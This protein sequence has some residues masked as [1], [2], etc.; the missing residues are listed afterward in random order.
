MSAVSQSYPNYLGGLNE[1]PDELKKPGQLVEALNVI[2]DPTVGLSRRPGFEHLP[3]SLVLENELDVK[4]DPKGTW[5]EITLTNQV[6]DDYIYFGNVRRDGAIVIFN[7]D[8]V[9]Q[10]VRYTND[11]ISLP[12]HKK[13]LYTDNDRVSVLDENDEEIQSDA[14]RSTSN[15]GYFRHTEDQP[16]KWCVSKNN[17]IFTNPK[18]T[19]TLSKGKKAG[20][21]DETTYY[22][23]ISLKVVDT[24]NYNY[25]FKLFGDDENTQKYRYIT[26]VETT[27]V[28][29]VEADYDKDTSL[30]LQTEGPFRFELGTAGQNGVIETATVE[31]TFRGQVEQLK[32]SGGDGYRNE[33]RYSWSTQIITPGKGYRNGQVFKN[34][35]PGVAGGPDLE[36]VF[37]VNETVEVTATE[38]EDINPDVTDDMS[39][40]DI[41]DALRTKFLA[42]SRI[43]RAIIVG[44]GIYLQAG[45]EFAVTTSEIAV[46]DVINSQKLEGDVIPL[47]RVNTVGE[48]PVECYTGFIV[49]VTNS[50]DDQSNYYLRYDSESETDELDITKGDGYWEEIAKPYE[51]HNPRDGTLPHMIS[52]CREAEKDRFVFVVSP[53]SYEKRTAGSLKDNPSLFRDNARITDVNYYK[54]RLFLLTSEGTVVTTRAGAIDNLFL[55]TAINISLI[56]PIDVIANNSQRVPIHGSSVINNGMILFG[57]SEQ[58]MLTTNSDILSSETVNV[59]KIAN[60]TFDPVSNPIYLGSNLGFISEGT[61]RFYELTN[62]YERGP[63]DINERSQQIQYLFGQGFNMPVSSREQSMAMV[64]KRGAVSTDMMVYRFRQEN[65][66]ESSQTSW[67]KW[68]VDG[69]VCY[70][71]MPRD[72]IFVFVEDEEKGAKIYKMQPDN[73]TRFTDGYEG[74]TPGIPYDSI[75]RFPTIY[76]RSG[77]SSDVMANTTIHRI[78][79]STGDIGAYDLR[80]DRKGYDT[81]NV[82]VEQTPADEYQSNSQP[83]YGEH[84]ETVPIY[85]R[86]K[87]LT[88]TMSTDYDAPMVLRSMTWEGDYNRP[89]YKSV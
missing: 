60:Y 71:S 57:D 25:V 74:D 67:V 47:A 62:L 83:I 16:L 22:S 45:N 40:K 1:Q 54:N 86:N 81:Y 73:D 3:Q 10:S 75:V 49:E 31:V 87:N 44:N 28:I 42:S 27:E 6:N 34:T 7:Q 39:A 18:E 88:L 23:F 41:L 8:G 77:E 64:Y 9:K 58:Y 46:A 35:L 79:F 72:E 55:D 13:Y 33:A 38:N 17:V 70:I 61:S 15:N 56:D 29:D 19:P 43:D 78:K 4:P 59:T 80:I 63:V 53:I 89:Y 2:P 84:V 30:P 12:P 82:L 37:S 76:P 65:S 21:R 51:S 20:P 48:L 69:N 52:I 68:R 14:L 36:F 11:N 26:E 50:F 32:S 5:F 24:A 85:T 66:Q